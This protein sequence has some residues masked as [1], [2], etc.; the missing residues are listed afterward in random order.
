MPNR[1]TE[2]KVFTPRIDAN[3]RKYKIRAYSRFLAVDFFT[4]KAKI[5]DFFRSNNL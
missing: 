2:S 1:K 3:E 4:E 5:S